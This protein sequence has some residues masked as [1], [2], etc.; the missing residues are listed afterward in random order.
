LTPVDELNRTRVGAERPLPSPVR[1][2]SANFRLNA[3]D[4]WPR[5]EAGHEENVDTRDF[6]VLP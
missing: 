2:G 5:D 3:E 1:Q 6:K 4:P